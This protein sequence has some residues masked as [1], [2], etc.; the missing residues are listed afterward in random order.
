MSLNSSRAAA[1]GRRR[2][3]LLP[4]VPELPEV[5]AALVGR[6][7]A[8]EQ[9]AGELVV[10]P[11]HVRLDEALVGLQQ[12]HAVRRD[13]MQVGH[14]HSST[15]FD[16]RLVHRHVELGV[17]HRLD[18]ALAHLLAIRGGKS[19][20]ARVHAERSASGRARH[21]CR[22]PRRGRAAA[23][24][25][26]AEAR[27]PRA[28]VLRRERALNRWPSAL[29]VRQRRTAGPAGERGF[30]TCNDQRNRC[31]PAAVDRLGH[32]NCPR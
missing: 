26:P 6:I 1:S 28:A 15:D 9:L 7:L 27:R 10:E 25:T 11:D 29:S 13:E 12:R 19:M 22:R 17:G 5:A 2:G 31:S 21:D 30:L 4:H 32:C 24:G 14:E 18:E 23:A 20:L 16:E 3:S 8:P